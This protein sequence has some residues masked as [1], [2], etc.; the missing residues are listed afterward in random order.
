LEI[1]ESLR[2]QRC[3][4]GRRG[5]RAL[6]ET[7]S[8]SFRGQAG[9]RARGTLMRAYDSVFK[10][11][12]S[13]RSVSGGSELSFSLRERQEHVAYRKHYFFARIRR[14][15]TRKSCNQA[16][17]LLAQAPIPRSA[18]GTSSFPQSFLRERRVTTAGLPG[19]QS[20]RVEHQPAG[21]GGAQ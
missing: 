5:P 13:R 6:R 21:E 17:A 19:A 9:W 12:G 15:K 14:G 10:D 2:S 3:R 8:S 20:V 11:R 7:H 18:T 16:G 1:G 4:N